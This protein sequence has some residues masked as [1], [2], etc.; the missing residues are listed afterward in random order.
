M[1]QLRIEFEIVFNA[2][3]IAAVQSP[4]HVNIYEVNQYGV[5]QSVVVGNKVLN[6]RRLASPRSS[7]LLK[8]LSR[9]E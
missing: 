4:L 7:E 1:L 8:A 2:N 6:F 5:L 3:F 9:A